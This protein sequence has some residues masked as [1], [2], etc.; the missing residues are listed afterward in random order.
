MSRGDSKDRQWW[1]RYCLTIEAQQRYNSAKNLPWPLCSS[2]VFQ[3]YVTQRAWECQIHRRIVGTR[4]LCTRSR[5]PYCP[6]VV[7]WG[8]I[9]RI[10]TKPIHKRHDELMRP[11]PRRAD[12]WCHYMHVVR[13]QHAPQS[14]LSMRERI[15]HWNVGANLRQMTSKFLFHRCCC[16]RHVRENFFTDCVINVWSC[17]PSYVYFSSSSSFKTS[18]RSRSIDLSAFVNWTYFRSV[19]IS[20]VCSV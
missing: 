20:L 9:S 11:S 1:C 13:R 19:H 6:V 14:E 10:R 5:L 16:C 7:A 12:W 3:R 2:A 4:P 15:H 8:D 17:L 18:I